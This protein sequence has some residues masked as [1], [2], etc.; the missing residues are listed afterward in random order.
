MGAVNFRFFS[1]SRLFLS[2]AAL[3]FDLIAS[4]CF[5]VVSSGGVSLCIAKAIVGKYRLGRS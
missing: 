3:G 4:N 2:N 1:S 5:C